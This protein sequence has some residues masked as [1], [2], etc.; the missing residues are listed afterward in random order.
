M[1]SVAVLMS[2]YNGELFLEE[3]L[4]S[5]FTQEG[6]QISVLVRDD[7]SVDSTRDILEKWKE[8][9]LIDW[10]CGQNL[11][12]A[13]S[14]LDLIKSAPNADYYAFCDQD[15]VWL[16][17]KLK[18]AVSKLVEFEED[19]PSLYF[20]AYQM[21]DEK[22][23]CIETHLKRP[24]ID[25]YHALVDN[26]AT[27]C[28]LVFNAK[29]LKEACRYTPS[30]I[31]MHDDW[32]YLLCHSLGGNVV[33]DESPHVLYRQHG[34]NAVGGIKLSLFEKYKIRIEKVFLKGNRY[35]SRLASEIL[36]GYSDSIS[37]NNL[38]VLNAFVNYHSGFRRTLIVFDYHYYKGYGLGDCIRLFVMFLT[39][40]I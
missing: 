26:S 11:K 1:V 17:D 31:T 27:G 39:G 22:L 12:P 7:G 15:D 3:Q 6:V 8:K 24:V 20:G 37:S 34:N 28:T 18:T 19:I 10:Y 4:D 14:F 32:L 5:L 16:P 25:L 38:K 40:K 13:L 30:F 35:R 33:Y 2:T 29:L 23:N 21:T 9:G 36:N